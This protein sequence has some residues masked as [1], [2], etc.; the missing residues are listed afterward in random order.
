MLLNLIILKLTVNL[1]RYRNIHQFLVRNYREEL[2][3]GSDGQVYCVVHDRLAEF[4][5]HGFPVIVEEC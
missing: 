1:L 5:S 3:Y 2:L 4:L